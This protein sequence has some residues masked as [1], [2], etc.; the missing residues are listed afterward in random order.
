MSINGRLNAQV[1]PGDRHTREPAV[2]AGSSSQAGWLGARMRGP[3][4]GVSLPPRRR[5]VVPR[6]GAAGGG[7]CHTVG[8]DAQATQSEEAGDTLPRTHGHRALG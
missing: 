7:A 4:R 1:R 5:W 2:W 3:E 6:V 8:T